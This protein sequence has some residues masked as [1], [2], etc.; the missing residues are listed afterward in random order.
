MDDVTRSA[1]EAAK[2]RR[3]QL[4]DALRAL[5]NSLSRS[6]ANPDWYDEVASRLAETRAALTDHI[7]EVE[8][9]DGLLEDI[10]DKA[11]R[12]SAAVQE[13]RD[14]HVRI[15]GALDALLDE[16]DRLR[17]SLIREQASELLTDLIRHR[18]AGADLVYEALSADIGGQG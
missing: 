17:R 10:V 9:A 15:G 14:D 6:V 4:R 2:K 1:F 3:I 8:A 13:M 5:E 11:P 16:L 18:Q 7:N 12:L